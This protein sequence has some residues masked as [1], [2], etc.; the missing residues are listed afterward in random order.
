M[1]AVFTMPLARFRDPA[2]SGDPAE[3]LAGLPGRTIALAAGIGAPLAGPLEGEATILIGAERDGLPPE[4]LAAASETCRIPIQAE[5]LN[6][7]MAATVALYELT[8]V[9]AA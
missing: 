4:L 8:R 6:A 7:A 9:P 5:S 1:G 3:L 2:H